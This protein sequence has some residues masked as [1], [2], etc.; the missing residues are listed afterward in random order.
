[1]QTAQHIKLNII[2]TAM[3]ISKFIVDVKN[4]PFPFDVVIVVNS[5]V[6]FVMVFAEP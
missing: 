3:P 4:I 5:V 1:M 6:F 2:K